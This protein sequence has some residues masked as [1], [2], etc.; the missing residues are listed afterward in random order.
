MESYLNRANAVFCSMMVCLS[1]LALGNIGSSYFLTNPI[2]GS[3]A[4]RDVYAFGYNYALS[5]DQAVLA[6]DIK[7]DLRGLFQWNAKQLF[8]FVV[9]E[10]ETPQHPANEVVVFDKIITHEEAAL[11]NLVNVPAK[12]HLR[13]K[14]KGLRGRDVTLKLQV[15]Y[16]PIVGRIST[17][18]VA[19]STFRMPSNYDRITSKQQHAQQR[20][21]VREAAAVA[22]ARPEDLA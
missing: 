1:V 14:G 16:H 8:L 12:Y 13:D 6:L 7:A 19:S 5:G 17:Q 3:V 22:S 9:A 10:Y 4:A 15:V 2:S 11:I 20:E 18:T 21:Q